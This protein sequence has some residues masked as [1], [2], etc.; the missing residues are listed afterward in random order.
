M[1]NFIGI[2]SVKEHYNYFTFYI[3]QP[4]SDTT[5]LKVLIAIFFIIALKSNP[6]IKL[7]STIKLDANFQ[8]VRIYL[9][10]EGILITN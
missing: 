10:V 3:C 6:S 8:F 1:H 5:P 2:K 9:T 4:F 7:S